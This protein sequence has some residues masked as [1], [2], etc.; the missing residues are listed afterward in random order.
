MT[1]K[2]EFPHVGVQLIEVAEDCADQRI[3][4]Y[5]LSRLK[6]LPR[7]RLYRILRK[8]EIRVN[9]KRIKPNYRLQAGDQIRIPPL[10]LAPPKAEIQPGK[11]LAEVLERSILFEN[12]QLLIINKP[13]GL[14]VH[15]G[16]GITLGLIEALR[17]IRPQAHFL[18]LVHRLDRDTSG[19]VMVAK[20][21][22]TL[23]ALHEDL[24]QGRIT[25]IYHALVIG[26]WPSA[27][28]RVDAPLL[29]NELKSGER[30]VKVTPQG[31][32]SLTLFRVLDQ[33]DGCTLVEAKPVTG[34]THQIR[35]HAQYVG[36]PIVGDD[37]YA[38]EK[39]NKA[40]R[41]RGVKRLF[42]HAAQLRLR[43]P[44]SQDVLRVT[45]PIEFALE[46]ALVALKPESQNRSV[47]D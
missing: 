25:K 16:S 34:R 33:L 32:E 10:R 29:K 27:I 14:A 19:C 47:I 22:S 28:S 46:K 4:N 44:G 20:K 42:L 43:L 12:E 8:G 26:C 35:V 7:T 40:M 5:L 30:V 18:E 17:Q 3:D 11:G 9:K 1:E 45:A 36:H 38:D 15:G 41:K 6:G 31:K 39:T 24:R 37:K 21:R 2:S 13:S 23:K